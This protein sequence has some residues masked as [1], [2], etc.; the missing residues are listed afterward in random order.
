MR[1][2]NVIFAALFCL[3]G[4]GALVGAAFFNAT[5]QLAVAGMCALMALVLWHTDRQTTRPQARR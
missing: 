5:H 3:L 1:T 2:M 4:A